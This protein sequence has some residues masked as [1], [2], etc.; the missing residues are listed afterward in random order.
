MEE[1]PSRPLHVCM[2]IFAAIYSW[3]I[4]NSPGL[5]DDKR[6]S[7]VGAASLVYVELQMLRG[8]YH[9][10]GSRHKIECFDVRDQS[11]E[12]EEY[13]REHCRFSIHWN[14]SKLS[15]RIRNFVILVIS[16]EWTPAPLRA[17]NHN[18]AREPHH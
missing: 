14:S 15:F 9:P 3:K 17:I 13:V 5:A 18:C 12:G 1:S 16:L 4:G 8:V 10:T 7:K 11:Q 2:Q 6:V